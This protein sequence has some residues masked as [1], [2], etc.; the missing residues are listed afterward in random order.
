[1]WRMQ[2]AR[3]KMQFIAPNL[4][5]FVKYTPIVESVATGVYSSNY[6][7]TL[8]ILNQFW[9]IWS[10]FDLKMQFIAHIC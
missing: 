3:T 1:M 4:Q 9:A 10:N 8:Y 2:L 7:C 6:L 5:I